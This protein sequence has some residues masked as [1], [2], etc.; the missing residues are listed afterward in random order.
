M[1]RIYLFYAFII[2]ILVSIFLFSLI[3]CCDENE[4]LYGTELVETNYIEQ[5]SES[6][7]CEKVVITYILNVKSKKIHK[8]TCGTG[9]LMLPENR[10]AFE[11]DIEDLFDQGYTRCGNC[12]RRQSD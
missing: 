10:R 6:V 5:S 11:G 2:V 1:R 12:F 9:N 8:V 4:T 3:A 7:V